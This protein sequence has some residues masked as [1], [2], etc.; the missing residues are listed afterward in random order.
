MASANDFADAINAVRPATVQITNQQVAFVSPLQSFEVPAG[1]GTG[2]IYKREGFIITNDHVIAGAQS[3]LVSLPDGRS[4]DARLVGRDP[5]TDLAVL[6]IDASNLPVAQLGDSAEVS[7]GDWD[8]AIGH[9]LGLPGG[10]TVTVGVVSAL[11]RT[12]QEPPAQGGSDPGP[13]LFD[14]IQT[15]AA[16][17]PGNSGGPLA[18]IEG[19]VIGINTLVAG[20]AAEGLPAQGIG[21]AIAIN[22]AKEIADELERNGRIA[23]AYLG[24]TYVPLNPAIAAQI[25]TDEEQGAV[26]MQVADGSPADDAGLTRGDVIT[27][28]DGEEIRGESD[29]SRLIDAKDPGD[30]VTL[31]VVRGNDTSEIE[32]TLGTA[33]TS[34]P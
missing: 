34:P 2:V 4:F 25:G 10:P 17:N 33:P 8:V 24:V 22:T 6:K 20:E 7:I 16:I 11:G 14:L 27:E 26:V 29:L 9:A 23:H 5:R 32:V 12:V 18:N 21:F 15:D 13:F 19:E 28:V 1:V 3:L 30:E 31:T